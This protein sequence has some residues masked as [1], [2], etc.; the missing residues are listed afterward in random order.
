VVFDPYLDTDGAE[1]LGVRKVD[2]STLLSESDIISLH[3][4]ANESTHHML[5][6]DAFRQMK[7]SALIMNKGYPDPW[8]W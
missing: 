3:A 2:M 7:D 6:R 8:H 5:G 4:P 1:A